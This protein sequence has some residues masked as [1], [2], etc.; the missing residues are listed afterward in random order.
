MSNSVF[1]VFGY[2]SLLDL[3]SLRMTAPSATALE[4]AWI[5][6]YRRSFCVVDA[7]GWTATNL[8]V[9]GEAFC[10]VGVVPCVG[11]LTNGVVFDV[12][13]D[14]FAA[15][16]EREKQYRVDRVALYRGGGAR[17]TAAVF[18]ARAAAPAM[19]WS[20]PAQ[21]RYIDICVQGAAQYGAAFADSFARTTWVGRERLGDVWPES[22]IQ[23]GRS[24]P[25]GKRR[26]RFLTEQK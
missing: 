19:Q 7:E 23:T 2:G 20:S 5:R 15:L 17:R 24:S 25:G 22:R 26:I 11:H 10:A 18:V 16:V 12:T 4:S 1:S 21:R 9:A 13:S 14:D 8:D 3:S 6:G